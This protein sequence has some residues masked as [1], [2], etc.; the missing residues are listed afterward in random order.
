MLY[1]TSLKSKLS[2][3]LM[4][5]K[6]RVT[7]YNLIENEAPPQYS[8]KETEDLKEKFL[9]KAKNA[10]KVFEGKNLATLTDFIKQILEEMDSQAELGVTCQEFLYCDVERSLKRSNCY[11]QRLFGLLDFNSDFYNW[12]KENLHILEM[13]L[14]DMLKCE[15]KV[16]TGMTAERENL[17]KISINLE[18]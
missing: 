4:K 14:K 9:R 11:G 5:T 3:V 8:E 17:I 6:E 1:F 7:S 15:V 18:K 2:G 16:E 10:R 12:L 13:N